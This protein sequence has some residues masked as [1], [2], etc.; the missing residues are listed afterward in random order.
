[1][2]PQRRDDEIQSTAW[3]NTT[4]T[5]AGGYTNQNALHALIALV[6]GFTG[7]L[8][9]FRRSG[10]SIRKALTLGREKQQNTAKMQE[11]SC[12]V[13]RKIGMADAELGSA[14]RGCL[15]ACTNGMCASA[16]LTAGVVNKSLTL[17]MAWNSAVV[18]G[19]R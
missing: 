11:R 12:V 8:L 1:M 17:H 5:T 18:E 2:L 3:N 16:A 4:S 10:Y 6:E 14:E 7:D 15:V 9:P 13:R 19:L